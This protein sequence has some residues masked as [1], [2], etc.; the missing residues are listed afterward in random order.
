MKGHIHLTDLPKALR[1]EGVKASYNQLYR[2]AMEGDIPA[3]RIGG[4]WYVKAHDLPAVVAAFT[5][6][7][8]E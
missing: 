7:P 4:R 3:E 8:E 6:A 1:A 2:R 5:P